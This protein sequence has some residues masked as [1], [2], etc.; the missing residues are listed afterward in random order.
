[1]S[2]PIFSKADIEQFTTLIEQSESIVILSH[3]NADGD[4]V[5]STTALAKLLRNAKKQVQIIFPNPYPST[6][7]FLDSHSDIIT[8]KEHQQQCIDVLQHCDLLLLLDVSGMSRLEYLGEKVNEILQQRNTPKI[9]IDHHLSPDSD[10]TLI[11]SDVTVSSTCELLYYLL[12]QADF[13]RYVC[14]SVATSIYTGI[15]TD[16]HSFRYNAHRS[17]LYYLVGSLMQ[18]NIDKSAV[19]RE[20]NESF[21]IERLQLLGF[22]LHE[23]LTLTENGQVA[24]ITLSKKELEHYQ[25]QPGD[26]DGLVNFALSVKSVKVSVLFTEATDRQF[27]RV[28]LR[29]KDDFSV[30]EFSRKY[31]N[32]GGHFNAAGGKFFD[33]DMDKCIR[34]F[35]ESIHETFNN[36]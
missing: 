34:Y 26:T 17:E 4:A 9:L 35:E 29:S 25:F 2:K 11:F 13:L 6:L 32:G 1:M 12:E 15:I 27:I 3:I 16:T 24:Y 28:S 14:N 23:K 18:Y 20:L 7:Q 10:F 8:Y 31:F 19:E 30:N 21:S 5:G 22:A 33:T 36:L